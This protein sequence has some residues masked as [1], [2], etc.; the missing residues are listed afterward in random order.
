MLTI[1]IYYCDLFKKSFLKKQSKKKL[2]K[3]DNE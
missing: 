2:E 3:N 1:A